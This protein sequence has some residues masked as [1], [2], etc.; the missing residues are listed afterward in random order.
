MDDLSRGLGSFFI[1]ML[2]VA[3]NGR[4]PAFN[5]TFG[6]WVVAGILFCFTGFTVRRD[7][8]RKEAHLL[9]NVRYVT[10]NNPLFD[11][12]GTATSS[13][14]LTTSKIDAPL[15]SPLNSTITSVTSD[16]LTPTHLYEDSVETRNLKM[17]P[18]VVPEDDNDNEGCDE[19][20]YQ[21][22]QQSPSP[23]PPPSV[24]AETRALNGD[25]ENQLQFYE[26]NAM[27]NT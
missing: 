17:F 21:D 19:A 2:V 18:V 23:S 24:S 4:I 7:L 11:P 15:K 3:L 13:E 22:A 5:V 8:R 6:G 9:A 20:H 14:S 10:D 25:E 16:G 27:T 26:R 12:N 1:A